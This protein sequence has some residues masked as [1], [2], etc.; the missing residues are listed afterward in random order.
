MSTKRILSCQM[1]G[2]ILFKTMPPFSDAEKCDE[3][4]GQLFTEMEWKKVSPFLLRT[5][6]YISR[7]RGACIA[8]MPEGIRK[9]F[10]SD[11][12]TLYSP[13]DNLFNLILVSSFDI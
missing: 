8:S 13:N 9:S 4:R 10:P 5:R 11:K 6:G 3:N 12:R 2:F 1:E 7:R